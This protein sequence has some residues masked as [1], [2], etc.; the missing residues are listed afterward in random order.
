MKTVIRQFCV[1]LYRL[2]IYELK[3][4]SKL[5]KNHR[6]SLFHNKTNQKF[7]CLFRI[8]Q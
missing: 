3:G 8:I 2:E 6:S 7:E 4:T 1:V 5:V